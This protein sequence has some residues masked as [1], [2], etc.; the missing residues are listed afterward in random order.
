MGPFDRTDRFPRKAASPSAAAVS[1]LHASAAATT[2]EPSA[3]ALAVQLRQRVLSGH[4][5]TATLEAWCSEHG[6]ADDAGLR[7]VRL[8]GAERPAPDAVR[9][10]LEAAPATPLHYRRVQLTCGRHVLSE[11][12]NWYL[13]GLLTA[14]MNAVLEASE[15]PFGRVVDALG[16]E[17]ETL[18]DQMFWPPQP[19]G[20]QMRVLELHVLLRDQHQRPFSYVIESY[21]SATLP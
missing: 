11:A 20:D 3:Y 2:P 19:L 16:F 14:D 4:S 6:M 7:A 13:P 18:S 10:A 9:R 15:A 17:R 21:L 1:S 12:D 8:A 5:A